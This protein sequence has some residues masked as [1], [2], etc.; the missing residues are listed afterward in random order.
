M[1]TSRALLCGIALLN[2]AFLSATG[3]E[4]YC[5]VIQKSV[6]ATTTQRAT[7]KA[8]DQINRDLKPLKRQHGAKLKLSERQAACLGG[9]ASI[10]AQG[11]QHYG[12][13]SC[14]VTQPFCVNP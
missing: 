1:K 4:A 7:Q 6:T 11:K 3:A 2:M 14:K 12:K 10:D 9:A 5:G 13:P 8:I